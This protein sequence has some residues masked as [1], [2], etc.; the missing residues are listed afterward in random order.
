M[1][2]EAPGRRIRA[3][4]STMKPS[5]ASYGDA[6]VRRDQSAQQER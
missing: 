2:Y 1:L 5:I 6:N 3:G 4:L